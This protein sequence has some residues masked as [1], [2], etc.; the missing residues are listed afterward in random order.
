VSEENKRIEKLEASSASHT[1][2]NTLRVG[3]INM[4]SDH[5]KDVFGQ[6]KELKGEGEVHSE[7]ILAAYNQRTELEKKYD[8]LEKRYEAKRDTVFKIGDVQIQIDEKQSDRIKR[9]EKEIKEL[10]QL[11][12]DNHRTV[13]GYCDELKEQQYLDAGEIRNTKQDIHEIRET[14]QEFISVYEMENMVDTGLLAMLGGEKTVNE[15]NNPMSSGSGMK[16]ETD[17]KPPSNEVWCEGHNPSE[18]NARDQN[19]AVG[20]ALRMALSGQDSKPPRVDV[21]QYKGKLPHYE[22]MDPAY[23]RK[24]TELVDFDLYSHEGVTMYSAKT[25]VIVEKEDLELSIKRETWLLEELYHSHYN[26]K[27]Y[28]K[29]W[30][31]YLIF[32]KKYLEGS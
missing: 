27:D 17:S 6:I 23:N 28:D 14:L 3:E 13:I 25:Q 22:N 9:L 11:V 20:K 15:V 4:L 5:F 18:Y 32:K 24:E 1:G 31:D 2:N 26:N 21:Y 7:Q 29:H 19:H 10:K 30:N 16:T 8:S 12:L